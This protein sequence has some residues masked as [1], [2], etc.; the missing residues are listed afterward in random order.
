MSLLAKATGLGFA[1]TAAAVAGG[2]GVAN[3]IGQF[4][5]IGAGG[6]DPGYQLMSGQVDAPIGSAALGAAG[7]GAMG[8]ALATGLIGGG[9]AG[10]SRMM[11]RGAS[12]TASKAASSS[13]AKPQGFMS[14]AWGDAAHSAASGSVGGYAMMAGLGGAANYATGGNFWEGA[15]A[16]AVVGGGIRMAGRSI[17]GGGVGKRGFL[18]N[19]INKTGY[20]GSAMNKAI[21][22]DSVSG[23]FGRRMSRPPMMGPEGPNS[24]HMAGKAAG[25]T[26]G[27]RMGGMAVFSGLANNRKHATLAG[28]GLAGMTFGGD[29]RSHSRGFNGHRGARI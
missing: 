14:R 13:G 10:I 8:V 26:G 9:A 2:V 11:G 18:G 19:M 25:A 3:S 21:G 16:G 24:F 22:G 28:A 15:A 4:G 23:M 1:G 5:G 12:K 6:E 7:V 20:E 17:A 29:R 27:T